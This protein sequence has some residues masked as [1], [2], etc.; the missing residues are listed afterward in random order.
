M[1]RSLSPSRRRLLAALMALCYVWLSTTGSF[2]HIEGTNTAKG[3]FVHAG[4]NRV[5]ELP[6]PGTHALQCVACDWQ[7]ANVSPALTPFALIF[8]PVPISQ[9]TETLLSQPQITFLH[10]DSRAPPAA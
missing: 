4:Q 8:W 9:I 10:S 1:V 3:V 7:N 5:A 6:E 2:L